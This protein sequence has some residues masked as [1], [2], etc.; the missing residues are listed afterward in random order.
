VIAREIESQAKPHATLPM[1]N[2][3]DPE[4]LDSHNIGMNVAH[5]LN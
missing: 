2:S 5:D 3:L 4:T 1:S